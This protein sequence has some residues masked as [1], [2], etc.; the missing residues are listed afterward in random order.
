M[1]R[2]KADLSS[3]GT[4]KIAHLNSDPLIHTNTFWISEDFPL[5]L[6]PKSGPLYGQGTGLSGLSEQTSL[7]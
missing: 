5:P 7:S 1:Q 3:Q 6:P 4:A 2:S